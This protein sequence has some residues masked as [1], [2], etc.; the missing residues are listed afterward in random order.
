V[1]RRCELRE[2]E[3]EKSKDDERHIA[4]IG[5]RSNLGNPKL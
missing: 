5:S 3:A 4:E 1:V 2:K